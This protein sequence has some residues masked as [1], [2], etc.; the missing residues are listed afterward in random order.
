MRNGLQTVVGKGGDW[1]APFVLRKFRLQ[2]EETCMVGDRLDTDIALGKSAGLRTILPL[3]GV[4]LAE[5]VEA[6]TE[7]ERPDYV[8]PSISDLARDL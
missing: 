4:C 6:A 3:T 1:L 8:V 5:D 7:A 2:P